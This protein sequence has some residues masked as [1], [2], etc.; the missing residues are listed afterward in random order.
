M[1]L[2]RGKGGRFAAR[3]NTDLPGA[4][5]LV[6]AYLAAPRG[7]D[8]LRE[9][10]AAAGVKVELQATG[11][12][13]ATGGQVVATGRPGVHDALRNWCNAARRK[14]AEGEQA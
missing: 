2:P 14:L 4:L 6:S 5:M 7:P 11:S 13:V 1:S 12:Y 3:S 9:T 10:L 8:H